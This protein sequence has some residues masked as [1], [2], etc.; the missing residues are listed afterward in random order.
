MLVQDIATIQYGRKAGASWDDVITEL[1][2]RLDP[3]PRAVR[4]GELTDI[5]T[6]P[7]SSGNAGGRERLAYG[8]AHPTPPGIVKN[9]KVP[10]WVALNDNPAGL[11]DWALTLGTTRSAQ[12]SVDT[13]TRAE[14]TRQAI[15]TPHSSSARSKALA[16]TLTT[17][18]ER[19]GTRVRPKTRAR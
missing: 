3:T 19:I 7:A 9:A 4:A 14:R 10:V 1:C 11:A 13:F 16:A 2:A 17:A 8:A 18:L 5:K 15:V 12:P 6:S